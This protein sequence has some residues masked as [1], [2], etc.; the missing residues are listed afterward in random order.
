MVISLHTYI[1]TYNIFK[2]SNNTSTKNP[3]YRLHRLRACVSSLA[4]F[5]HN[6]MVPLARLDFSPFG[7]RSR[8]GFEFVRDFLELGEELASR[9]PSQAAT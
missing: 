7:I 9:L 1:H 2:K 3:R 5:H 6:D 8:A 4:P